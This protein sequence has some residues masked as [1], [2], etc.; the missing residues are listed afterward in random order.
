MAKKSIYGL[1]VDVEN[2]KAEPVTLDGTL[3]GYYNALN[4]DCID[5]PRR[6][7]NGVEYSIVCDDEGLMVDSPKISAID[8]DNEPSLV[9]NLF[10]AMDGGDGEL[11]SLTEDEMHELRRHIA[12][13][14]TR[15]YPEGYF[16]L[17]DIEG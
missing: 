9:G 15:N 4:C 3:N 14:R 17:C 11:R 1:L 10:V 7:I 8:T 2:R 6:V 13:I 16:V 5:I 12:F